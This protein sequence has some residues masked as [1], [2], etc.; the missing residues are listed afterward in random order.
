MDTKTEL[1]L[2]HEI[3]ENVDATVAITEDKTAF[4]VEYSISDA[5]TLSMS[6]DSKGETS[7]KLTIKI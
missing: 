5:T 7:A 1:D 2:K 3:N 6:K 4:G